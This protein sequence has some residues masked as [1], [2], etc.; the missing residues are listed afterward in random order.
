ML[1]VGL[2]PLII[3]STISSLF[4]VEFVLYKCDELLLW[5][6]VSSSTSVL[7]GLAYMFCI[8]AALENVRCPNMFASLNKIC[9]YCHC[10]NCCRNSQK[11]WI[12]RWKEWEICFHEAAVAHRIKTEPLLREFCFV[13]A[14][15]MT[16]TVDIKD[17]SRGRPV[18]KAKVRL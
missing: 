17:D 13:F 4:W 12:G 7:V 16:S 11:Q 1:S 2:I 5:H 18:Q 6:M 3:L 15:I 10:C 9:S 14:E 8:D